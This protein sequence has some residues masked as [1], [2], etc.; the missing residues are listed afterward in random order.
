MNPAQL[1]MACEIL[2]KLYTEL[3]EHDATL[4]VWG[5]RSQENASDPSSRGKCAHPELVDEC[6]RVMLGQ[7][8]GHRINVPAQYHSNGEANVR[9]PEYEENDTSIENLLFAEEAL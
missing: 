3:A 8:K 7:E 5:L 1:I 6:F 2:D 9:H 4:R